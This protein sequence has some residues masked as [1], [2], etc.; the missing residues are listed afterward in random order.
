M[1]WVMP[2]QVVLVVSDGER[3]IPRTLSELSCAMIGMFLKDIGEAKR[4]GPIGRMA[5]LSKL[6][7]SLDAVEKESMH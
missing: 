7:C 3:N 4:A 2:L 6:G 1:P 5:H